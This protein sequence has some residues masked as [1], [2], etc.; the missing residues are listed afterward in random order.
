MIFTFLG[1]LLS[2]F[3]II[4]KNKIKALLFFYITTAVT[5]LLYAYHAT[6]DLNL[7]F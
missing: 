5:L 3:Y 7:N 2:V 6:S 1:Y 4:R